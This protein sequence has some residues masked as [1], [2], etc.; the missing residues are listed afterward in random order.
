MESIV[1]SI[2]KYLEGPFVV[3]RSREGRYRFR[4]Q[5]V[6]EVKE[7]EEKAESKKKEWRVMSLPPLHCFPVPSLSSE[8]ILSLE[9]AMI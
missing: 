1:G 6:E 9:E 2:M 5:E 7:A 3:S 8:Q 4:I